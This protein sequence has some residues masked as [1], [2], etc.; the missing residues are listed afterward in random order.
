MADYCIEGKKGAGKSLIAVRRMKWYL[1]RGLPVATNLDID[2]SELMGPFNK[3]A[4]VYRVPDRPRV[5]DLENLGY[6]NETPDED[7]NGGLFFDECA[8][9]FNSRNWNEK[10]RKEV[11]DWLLHGRKYGWDCYYLIQSHTAL[12]SQARES[13]MEHLV[14]IRRTDRMAIPFFGFVAKL[15]TGKR[16]QLPKGHLASVKYVDTDQVVDRWY[17]AGQDFYDSYDTK[18]IFSPHYI[19]ADEDSGVAG[20]YMQIP[21]YMFR[22]KS[23]IERNKEFWMRLSKAY[24]KKLNTGLYALAASLLTSAIWLSYVL[25]KEPEPQS[26]NVLGEVPAETRRLESEPQDWVESHF[27]IQSITSYQ[28]ITFNRQMKRPIGSTRIAQGERV[29]TIEG[30]KQQG[31]T[32]HYYS[33]CFQ[34][35]EK[36]PERIIASCPQDLAETPS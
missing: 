7:F 11:N 6:A 28:P 27:V 4:R 31:Y 21:P 35:L 34:I 23:L 24:F 22:P 2:L 26:G 25:L 20:L 30:L 19:A 8:T 36:S 5:E 10:G 29:L 33:D 18:Q 16:L 15:L 9:W 13:V 1:E 12:D 14:T 17:A 3:D 32:H